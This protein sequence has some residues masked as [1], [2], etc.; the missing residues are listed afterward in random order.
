MAVRCNTAAVALLLLSAM[1]LHSSY[2]VYKYSSLQLDRRSEIEKRTNV[3][4]DATGYSALQGDVLVEHE[5]QPP[6][7]TPPPR[8]PPA[9]PVVDAKRI[10]VS[11]ILRSGAAHGNA[12]EVLCVLVPYRDSVD[13]SSQGIG[14]PRIEAGWVKGTVT[15]VG[16]GRPK[17]ESRGVYS[18]HEAVVDRSRNTFSDC[19]GRTRTGWQSE[20]L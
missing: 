1:F 2:I 20:L 18:V 6:P 14:R 15:C 3:A 9:P 13:N 4:S 12:T 19:R 8:A 10:N 16:K 11:D 5:A 17:G 7:P